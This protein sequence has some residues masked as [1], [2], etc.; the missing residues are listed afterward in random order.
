VGAVNADARY[1][2][3]NNI[4]GN[5][6]ITY[7]N[8]APQSEK[9]LATLKPVERGGYYVSQC[10]KGTREDIF[11]NI[12]QWLD[13]VDA[14]NVLWLSGIPGAGKSAI[15]SS[16]VS[17]LTRHRRLGSSFFFRRGDVTLSD[18]AA[19]WRTIT[20]NLAK[21]SSVFASILIRV[22]EQ[23]EVDPDRP[24]IT[25]HFQY[26]IQEPLMASYDHSLSYSIP[27]ILVDALDECDSDRSQPAQRKVLLDTLT[28]WSRFPRALKL[29][30][31]GRDDRVPESFRAICQQIVL[32][33]GG[34]V[35]A[36]A[37]ND[38]RRFFE[39]RFTE[40]GGSS[41]LEWPGKQVLDALTTRAAGLFIWA[42]TVVKFVEQGFPD[43]RL[44]LVLKGELGGSDNLTK[45]YRQIL[46]L[47]FQG[48][49]GPELEVSKFVIAA[50]VLAKLPLHYDDLHDFV[51]HSKLSVR[52]VLDKLS[53]VISS[54]GADKRLR[55]GHMSFSEFL[56]D[57][58]RCPQQFFIDGGKQSRNLTM[59][60]F[61]L[62]KDRLRFNI[63]NLET[64]HLFNH[65]VQD[66]PVRIKTNIPFPL[67]YSCRF[68]AAHLRDT[69]TNQ[70]DHGTLMREVKDFLHVR[71]LY[72]LEVMS[73]TEG[74]SA[75]NVALL[76]AV[77]WIEVS[78]F[79]IIVICNT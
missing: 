47:S 75:A 8:H 59:A 32:P 42:E 49:R 54:G 76:T 17:K 65:N 51:A 44:K 15:A 61:R 12:D 7:A 3:F 4:A 62:M 5:Q 10:M 37:N 58:K 27:V 31:T 40:I 38:I 19:L 67:L 14:P 45:L 39:E 46:E 34:D 66:L 21:S 60:C 55:I 18:P 57:R 24:D 11:K 77:R 64:S 13:D 28:Q 2:T 35:S 41:F 69:M 1:S 25:S 23:R 72:W 36:D 43:E 29:I 56:C 48:I 26:L 20:F 71:L 50:I 6:H 68:W 63:C 70:D 52:F 73:L 22:L 74:V 53:S 9:I 33:T 30:V 79:L 16:L 78:S